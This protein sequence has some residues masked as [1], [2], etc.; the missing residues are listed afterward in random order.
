[1]IEGEGS[2]FTVH[3]FDGDVGAKWL[4]FRRQGVG[5]SDVAALMGLSAYKSPYELWCEKVGVLEAPDLS[6]KG[7]VE[8]GNRL[9]PLVGEKYAEEHPDRQVRRVNGVCRSLERPWAQASLDFEVKDPELGW[10]VLEIKTVG[11]RRASDWDDGVPVYYQTQAAHYMGVTGR[12]FCD[13][14]VLIGGQE[15]REYRLL[16]DEE[17]EAAVVEAVDAFWRSVVERVPPDPTGSAGEPR[18]IMAFRGGGGDVRA[19]EA[20]EESLLKSW[21]EFKALR[22]Q[23]DEQYREVSNRLM[24]SIGS[25]RAVEFPDGKLTWVRS[26]RRRVDTKALERDHPELVEGYATVKTENGGLRWSPRK[27]A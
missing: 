23:V 18:A 8:W 6:D 22:D 13:F 2:R 7:A 3:R 5:G 17:D 14:A 12:K 27:G 25:D 9:E 1:M 21:L 15:Y 20:A 24:D 16:A 19:S 10:G 26:E 11:L 4:E